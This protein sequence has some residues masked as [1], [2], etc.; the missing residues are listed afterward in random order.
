MSADPY[1]MVVVERLAD[2][3]ERSRSDDLPDVLWSASL[4]MIER[5]AGRARERR[6]WRSNPSGELRAFRRQMAEALALAR[7]AAA[8]QAADNA[9]EWESDAPGREAAELDGARRRRAQTL[10]AELARLANA[11]ARRSG[12]TSGRNFHLRPDYPAGGDVDGRRSR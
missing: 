4:A 9:G 10:P 5:A 11:A 3:L 6:W 1:R 12:A 2:L 7:L 8:L